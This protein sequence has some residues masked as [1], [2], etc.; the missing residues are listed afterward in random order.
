MN[1]FEAAARGKFRYETPNGN[2]TTEQLFELPLTA[3][4]PNRANLNDI[5]ILID[6][7][8]ES[9]GRKS[10]VSTASN[11]RHATLDVMLDVVKAVIATKMAAAADAAARKE[12][13]E[14]RNK[15]L[16]AMATAENRELGSKSLDQLKADLAALDA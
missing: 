16:D 13:L 12:K 14:K 9:L 5:A 10:F 15:I 2:L 8:R 6:D 1:I 4:A 11:P 7:E 3:T